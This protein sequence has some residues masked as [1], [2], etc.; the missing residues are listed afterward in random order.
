M[1][2]WEGPLEA[3]RDGRR[4][5][6]IP[7]AAM[8]RCV[9]VMF[10]ARLGSLNALAQT[11]GSRFWR[12][13]L[14]GPMP[15]A[16][17][18]GRV[19]GQV[20]AGDARAVLAREYDRLKRGKAL[21]PPVHGLM[22]GVVDGHES[23]ATFRQCC[24]GCLERTVHTGQGDR[25]Q[26]YH[27]CVALRLVGRD[28]EMMLD[29]EDQRRG[30]DEVAAAMRLLERVLRNHPR[31]FDV[32]VG[33]GLYA[34]GP[35]FNFVRARGKHVLA[36]LKDEQRDLLQ[37]ARGLFET[38]PPT[39]RRSGSVECTLWDAEGFT[40]WPQVESPVRVV[41]SVER[42]T[43]R[44]QLDGQKEEQ[45]SEW[46][47]V[48]TLPRSMASALTVV[49]MGHG[50]WNIENEGF[51]D[52][53]NHWHIDHVYKHDPVAIPVLWLLA[54][55]CANLFLAFYRRNLKPAARAA[56]SMIHVGRRIAAELYAA[57]PAGPDTAP[58]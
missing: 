18:V 7:T 30:E 31:A 32:V 40:T 17:T 15:S 29:V 39:A 16:D 22:A 27:R 1:L 8:V 34:R 38:M 50:R 46:F 55:A 2:G 37:D 3:I 6:R 35:F 47:W 14:G 44:R 10:L 48:T 21:T 56:A 5:A 42:R 20:E 53:V 24:G 57:L 19:A 9:V 54:M 36:V 23:H 51:N 26:Y 25:I 58:T 49:Q 43:I 52:L 28:L 13:F 12:R 45:T 41:R 11:R 4:R 33:D